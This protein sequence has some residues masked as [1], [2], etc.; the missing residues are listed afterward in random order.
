M[1]A[2]NTIVILE[3]NGPEFRVAD[4]QAAKNLFYYDK[5]G[6]LL[7]AWDYFHD[8][9]IFKTLDAALKEAVRLEKICRKWMGYGPEY[10]ITHETIHKTFPK[11]KPKCPNHYLASKCDPPMCLRCGEG[12]KELK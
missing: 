6:D 10:G 5:T 12:A 11:K 3:T 8:L 9:P 1:S 4:I 7:S 2:D